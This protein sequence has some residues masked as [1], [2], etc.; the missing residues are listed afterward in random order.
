MGHNGDFPDLSV[1]LRK[2]PHVEIRLGSH[3]GPPLASCK[4]QAQSLAKMLL[5]N[6]SRWL[7]QLAKQPD[8]WRDL[9]GEI[10]QEVRQ[11]TGR[12]LA[13][14]LQEASQ[15]SAFVDASEEVERQAAVPIKPP[16][17]RPSKIRLLCGLVLYVTT[18]YCPPRPASQKYTSQDEDQEQRAGLF[19][20]LVALGITLGCTPAMMETVARIV[21]M[22]PSIAVAQRELAQQGLH[23][24]KKTVR[25]IAVQCGEQI[26]ALRR[27]E[28][29]EWREG[30]LPAGDELAGKRVAVQIDG[31]RLR[32]RKTKPSQ[33][34]P[35]KGKRKKYDTPWR[36]PKLLVIYTFNRQGKM[37]S[38]TCQ[39]LIEG[40]LLGPDH[41]AELV[42]FHLHRLGAARAKEVVFAADGAPWIWDRIDWIVQRAG[43]KT[44]RV[45]QVLDF[46]HA[47]H[48]ISLALEALGYTGSE[49]QQ[50]Y[51]R[52]RRQLK[53]GQ[54]ESV[55]AQLVAL[56]PRETSEQSSVWTELDYLLKHGEA[57][58]LD[59]RRFRRRGI[60][61]GS[62][63]IESTIRRVINL[64]FKNNG[65][66]W[67]EENA[68]ALFAIR[69]L[70]LSGRWDDTLK[71]VRSS[72]A[73]DR[74]RLWK[75]QAPDIPAELKAAAPAK[76]DL[77]QPQQTEPLTTTTA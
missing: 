58:R 41:L 9:E 47:A 51:R 4:S 75:W 28:L 52:L 73:R 18:L 36:E 43:V 32:T 30:N 37:T 44:H 63:A 29:F 16:L 21:V 24:D 5:R 31:G 20:E 23:L 1:V 25:R 69:G 68:E 34:K 66:F 14:L 48:H 72:I 12:F 46:C 11:H 38:K 50:I 64:R 45:T 61:C 2:E 77:K 33:K 49:R 59:Y 60:P 54:W 62:G 19:P 7:R 17:R 10:D 13:A 57:G 70:W 8:S 15:E 71:R 56:A 67:R 53:A 39:P 27:R 74:R 6:R 35:K 22:N 3:D 55:W 42:A 76:D 65:M 40:T 26:L